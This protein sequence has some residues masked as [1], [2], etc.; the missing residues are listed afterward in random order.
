MAETN[1]FMDAIN[2][3]FRS[4]GVDPSNTKYASGVTQKIG[5]VVQS[6]K[7][8]GSR[9][10]INLADISKQK[11]RAAYTSLTPEQKKTVADY[12]EYDKAREELARSLSETLVSPKNAQGD[13]RL[14]SARSAVDEV[15]RSMREQQ[16]AQPTAPSPTTEAKTTTGMDGEALSKL[17]VQAP[18]VPSPEMAPREPQ[19]P[20]SMA[21]AA[22]SA[23]MAEAP[24]STEAMPPK[25]TP[26]IDD[27]RLMGLFSKTMGTEFDPKS[28]LD[29]SKLDELRGFVESNPDMLGK[30]DTKI[31]LDYY[32]S[33]A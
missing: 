4:F 27:N 33:K 18:P 28:R 10:R 3:R 29:R 7:K 26:V 1:N 30:S 21:Q 22:P 13:V 24:T 8:I 5:N 6:Q 23:T 20:A 15:A 9:P 17:L 16:Y 19:T 25:A 2:A 31:A 12:E 32:R 11:G 14:D